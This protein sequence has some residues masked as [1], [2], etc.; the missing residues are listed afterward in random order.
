MLHNHWVDQKFLKSKK[1]ICEKQ[2]LTEGSENGV[3]VTMFAYVSVAYFN[4]LPLRVIFPLLSFPNPQ[5]LF[6]CL[7]LSTLQNQRKN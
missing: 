5:I 3:Y 7:L 2:I 1:R 4:I 6:P